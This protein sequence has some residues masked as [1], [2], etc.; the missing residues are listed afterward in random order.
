[1]YNTLRK[2]KEKITLTCRV[3][4]GLSHP[5]YT[6]ATWFDFSEVVLAARKPISNH[7]STGTTLPLE[8]KV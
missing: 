7:K 6:L 4:S 8:S 5:D 2:T 1:M 3:A